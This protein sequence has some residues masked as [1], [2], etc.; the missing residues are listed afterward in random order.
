M[1]K[2]EYN[3]IHHWIRKNYNKA[4]KCS[5][6][7][8]KHINP[9]RFEWAL[10]KGCIYDYKIENFIEL[11][12]SCHRK[13][14]MTKELRKKHSIRM[15][16]ELINGTRKNPQQNSGKFQGNH[17][18]S[19]NILKYTKTNLFL[20][21]YSSLAEASKDTNTLSTS[22]TNCLTKRSKS[23]GGF[24]WLYKLKK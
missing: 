17:Q 11:C 14:D 19:K 22:I 9:K 1:T 6:L 8:C 10:K 13:Y 23:A 5:N 21:E 2:N 3:Y 12:P 16:K 18:S 24:I 20:K 4:S 7:D 15:S